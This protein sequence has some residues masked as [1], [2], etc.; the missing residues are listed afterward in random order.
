MKISAKVLRRFCSGVP[1]DAKALR[2]LL[3][4]LGVEVKRQD[5]QAGD[6]LLTL[7]LLANRGD[8]HC[9]AGVAREIA[10]RTKTPLGLPNA[11]TLEVGAPPLPLRIESDKCL[12][13][14]AT[15][16]RVTGKLLGSLGKDADELLTAAGLLTGNAAID[17]TNLVNLEIGQPSHAFDRARIQGGITIRLSKAGEKAWLL[18][19]PEPREL[20]PGTLVIADDTKV[21]AIAGVIGCEDSKITDDTKEIIL[22]CAAFDPVTVRVGGRALATH[23]DASARFERGSDPTLATVA[24]GRIAQLLAEAGIA[25]TTGPLGLVGAW[26]DP[27]RVVQLRADEASH[28]LGRDF[29]EAEIVER[30]SAYGFVHQGKLAFRVPPH[31]IWDVES[32][33][34]LFEELARSV[35]F[36]D[37]PEGLPPVG[38][39]ARPSRAEVLT[40]VAEDV[41]VGAGFY[42]IYTDGFYSRQVPERLAQREGSPLFS[43]V[44]TINSLDNSFSL[45]KNNCLAQAVQAVADNVNVKTQD[46]RLYEWTRTFHPDP[47]ATNKVC[48][49]RDVL[50]GICSGRERPDAWETG[51]NADVFFLKGLFEQL[52]TTLD[53]PLTLGDPDP[54]YALTALLHPHRCLSVKHA[55]QSVGVIGEVLPSVLQAFGVKFAKACYFELSRDVLLAEPRGSAAYEMPPSMPDIDRMLSFAV[56]LGVSVRDIA[57]L[58]QSAAPAWLERISVADVFSGSGENKTRAVAFKLLFNATEPRTSEQLNEACAAMV[59]SVVEKLGP[60]GVEQ[61]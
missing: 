29:A 28:F 5:L 45:L 51:R 30:L 23:T 19:T 18:F 41:L 11:R 44:E 61:R 48:R 16:L 21:L 38:L 14:T 27:A 35:G 31:R 4:D 49:E 12:L 2:K 60:R 24:A 50:Y 20:P 22:E 47:Q 56:P 53:L 42:E 9:Y 57:P 40:S 39:G 37:L 55:G 59:K 6:A 36:N 34:D 58:L 17:V 33:E 43:H 26:Q 13:Y 10:A 25:E 8:H 52:I 15:P 3:D 32:E 54:S 46:V 1:Q 7:E